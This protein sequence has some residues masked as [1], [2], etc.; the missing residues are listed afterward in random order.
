MR[1]C[2]PILLVACLLMLTE[3][4]SGC[5]DESKTIPILPGTQGL[6][7]TILFLEGNFMPPGVGIS[8]PVER[9]LRIY[10]LTTLEQVTRINTKYPGMFISDVKTNLVKKVYSDPNGIFKVELPPGKYSLMVVDGDVLY[11]NL[12]GGSGEIFPVEIREDEY[13]EVVFKIDYLAVY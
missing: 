10:E 12:F 8:T 13:K 5:S 9:E 4:I 6:Q 11:V 3:F 2:T 1:T 7:G